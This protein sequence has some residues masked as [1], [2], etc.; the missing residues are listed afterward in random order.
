MS[1][2]CVV[3][4]SI[5]KVGVV[6]TEVYLL[7][8]K[9]RPVLLVGFNL[10][11]VKTFYFSYPTHFLTP[12]LRGKVLTLYILF[13]IVEILVEVIIYAFYVIECFHS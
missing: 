6:E 7:P 5:F 13:L 3:I 8:N 11:R 9:L 4:N 10:R 12:N 2:V 1:L